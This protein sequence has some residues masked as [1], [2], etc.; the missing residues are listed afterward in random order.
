MKSL[1]SRF[2][3]DET[4]TT[5]IEYALIAAIVGV[6]I[7]AALGQLRTSLSSTFNTVAGNLTST[8]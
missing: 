7:I 3:D 5:A 2:I 6:G 1:C 4:G 8:R